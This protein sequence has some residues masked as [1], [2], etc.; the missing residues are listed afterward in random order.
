MQDAE[1]ADTSTEAPPQQT[2]STPRSS[3]GTLKIIK[4]DELDPRYQIMPE[5]KLDAFTT[6][7]AT[8]CEV[9]DK[10][11]AKKSALMAL[12]YDGQ[13]PVPLPVIRKLERIESSCIP[14]V[15]SRGKTTIGGKEQ[16]AVV[17]QRPTGR[18]FA[19]IL[20]SRGAFEETFVRRRVLR[21]MGEA[22]DELAEE[23]IVCGNINLDTVYIDEK[24]GQVMLSPF[25]GTFCGFSQKPL[26]ETLNRVVCEPE[27]KGAQGETVDY[28][29]VAVLAA[30][31]LA[32]KESFSGSNRQTIIKT[33][34]EHG[35]YETAVSALVRMKLPLTQRMQNF[36]KGFLT[37][38]DKERWGPDEFLDWINNKGAGTLPAAKL[39][40][41]TGNPFEF[42]GKQFFSR[43]SLIEDMFHNWDK[44]KKSLQL[45]EL[46]RWV[47]LSLKRN[48]ISEY[49]DALITQSKKSAKVVIPDDRLARIITILDPDG[50]IHFRKYIVSIYGI[51]GFLAKG[52]REG[53]RDVLQHVGDLLNEGLVEHW[54]GMQ[55]NPD[56]YSYSH[57]LWSPNKMLQYV[58][59]PALGFGLER[60]LYDFNPDLPCQSTLVSHKCCNNV[61]DVL[62]ALED[63]SASK[64]KET[65]P[66]D[67]HIAGFIGNKIDLLDEIRIKSL[68]RFPHLLR[69]PQIQML[70]L[71][72]VAQ[73]QSSADALKG[74]AAWLVHRLESVSD[75]IHSESIE[76]GFRKAL[77]QGAKE[78]NL[79]DLYR[80][81]ADPSSFAQDSAGFR[82]AK[83]HYRA[84]SGEVTKLETVSN[85]EQLAY[86]Y[87]LRLSMIIS[88]LVLI[89]TI[90]II[91]LRIT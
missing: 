80:L 64:M 19:E 7:F 42:D 10:D 41:E 87:G 56:D 54:I 43:K 62:L 4:D 77:E 6:D 28:F 73:S 70:A 90:F 14:Q 25:V 23:E 53:D 9:K 36:L 60:C 72:T 21:P 22:L 37:D 29:A 35:S 3:I 51:G 81:A 57:L 75:H 86:H 46:S 59:K 55:P 39:H 34:L 63:V 44:A 5:R 84:I 69:N 71:L 68:Q 61:A 65:D 88:Y 48:D 8:A 78:G 50:P 27:A 20:Q 47:K 74:L 85:T 45:Y 33:R 58:K 82:E 13:F 49:L 91:F 1:S 11:T 52:Y 76:A 67:R 2:A 79:N 18:S 15:L 30:C 26:F 32:G 31:L 24:T 12:V 83:Q 40:K 16:Y 17:M 38:S 66:V 89:A